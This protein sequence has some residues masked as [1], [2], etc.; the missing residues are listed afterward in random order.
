MKR[1]RIALILMCTF[2]PT[3]PAYA[4]NYDYENISP[5]E[6]DAPGWVEDESG[7]YFVSPPSP[8]ETAPINPISKTDDPS[9]KSQAPSKF[10]FQVVNG[11]FWEPGKRRSRRQ[12]KMAKAEEAK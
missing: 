4:Q 1:K 10:R 12:G 6:D 9:A 11:D 5:Y 2:S 3:V 7:G 8:P